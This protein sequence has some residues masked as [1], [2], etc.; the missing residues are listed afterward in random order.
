MTNQ[1]IGSAR[2]HDLDSFLGHE[3]S[4]GGGAAFLENW[5]QRTPPLVKVVLHTEAPPIS[6][7]QHRWP[8][9]VTREVDGKEVQMV[10]NNDFNSWESEDVLKNQYLRDDDGER[11][12]PPQVCPMA[13]MLE[14]VNRLMREGELPWDTLL[15]VFKGDNKDYDKYLF[16]GAITNKTKKI[17]EDK[18]T[19]DEMKRKARKKGFPG[20]ADAWM[21]NMMA[22]CQYVLTVVDYEDVEAGI[23]IAKETS[24]VGDKLKKVIRDRRTS[25]GEDE[26]NPFLNPYVIQFKH[27]PKATDFK[28]KYDVVVIAKLEITDE[29]KELI[30]DKDPPNLD[31]YTAPGDIV[32]LRASMEDNYC[33]PEGLLDWDFIFTKAEAIL[34]IEDGPDEDGSDESDVPEGQEAGDEP[35]D[36]GN[37]PAGDQG[38]LPLDDEPQPDRIIAKRKG[39][40]VDQVCLNAA[41]EQLFGCEKCEAIMLESED[42]CHNCGED[43]S[44]ADAEPDPEP[45]PAPPPRRPRSAKG[46]NG[47]AKGKTGAA[48]AKGG[49]GTASARAAASGK[50]GVGF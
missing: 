27:A 21:T 6:V 34:G 49:K 47:S 25:E 24:L 13:I 4:G 48:K 40:G 18:Q 16:A 5:K 9:I 14:E 33:G 31:R 36:E 37:P 26:G 7:Y 28:D 23:Q 8:K 15:F 41:G 35:D 43:Y 19:T 20:P 22:K 30:F 44:E 42:K 50:D 46:K 39:K 45:E 11:K 2:K 17:W 38:E 29:I 32:A 10:Y 3:S 12:Y 1:Q